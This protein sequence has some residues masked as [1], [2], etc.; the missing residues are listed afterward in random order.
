MVH[1]F[2]LRR[3]SAEVYFVIIHAS[4]LY[5]RKERLTQNVH[6][7]YALMHDLDTVEALF[8]HRAVTVVLAGAGLPADLGS[9]ILGTAKRH[10]AAVEALGGENHEQNFSAAQVRW[11][12]HCIAHSAIVFLILHQTSCRLWSSWCLKY[13]N[14]PQVKVSL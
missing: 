3:L 7:L 8:E 10:L 6:L 4:I 1:S 11:R 12:L 13:E 14:R 9:A 5:N 2:C